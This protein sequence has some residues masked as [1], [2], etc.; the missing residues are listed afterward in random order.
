M[1]DGYTAAQG[2]MMSSM[3][4]DIEQ[5]IAEALRK[6]G[7][8]AYGIDTDHLASLLLADLN[9]LRERRTLP[10]G[11]GGVTTN[12]KTGETT[13]HSRPCT[14]QSRWVTN[15]VTDPEFAA[16]GVNSLSHRSNR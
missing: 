11:M 12:W 2:G 6:R 13:F 8:H 9:L 14:A 10:D 15:W 1:S 3:S 5:R 7:V 16:R 4:N